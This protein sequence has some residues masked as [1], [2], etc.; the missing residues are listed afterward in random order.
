VLSGDEDFVILACVVLIQYQRVT[1]WRTDGRTD[2]HLDRSYINVQ[3]VML[4]PCKKAKL[5][6]SFNTYALDKKL[7]NVNFVI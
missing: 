2:R 3:Q 4:T 1:E 5:L 6:N 7:K